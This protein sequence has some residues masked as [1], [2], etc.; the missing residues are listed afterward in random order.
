MDIERMREY[1]RS[2]E[3]EEFTEEVVAAAVEVVGAWA[4]L[5]GPHGQGALHVGQTPRQTATSNQALFALQDAITKMGA[6][7]EALEGEEA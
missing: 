3:V 2:E 7:L 4:D 6:A 5:Q 1:A